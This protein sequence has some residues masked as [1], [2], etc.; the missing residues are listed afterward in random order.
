[1][2]T[3][4]AGD[5]AFLV[6]VKTASTNAIIL[7]ILLRV[8]TSIIPGLNKF[9]G[10]LLRWMGAMTAYRSVKLSLLPLSIVIVSTFSG[11]SAPCST[12]VPRLLSHIPFTI[13]SH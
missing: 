2:G 8:I 11:A 6:A 7:E 9:H 10:K 12:I 3:G 13:I 1:V 4:V 5:E